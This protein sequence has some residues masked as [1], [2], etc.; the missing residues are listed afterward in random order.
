MV[1]VYFVRF[2]CRTKTL[3]AYNNNN[4]NNKL[5]MKSFNKKTNNNSEKK[6][7]KAKKEAIL[8][9]GTHSHLMQYMTPNGGPKSAYH[10]EPNS[11]SVFPN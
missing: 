5:M 11:R 10:V 3:F 1:T 2:C 4:N 9:T 7:E 6:S 8:L